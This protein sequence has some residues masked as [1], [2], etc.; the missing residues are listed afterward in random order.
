MRK[1]W[2][3]TREVSRLLKVSEASVRRWSDAGLMPVERVG[4]RG[5]R[6]FQEADVRRFREGGLQTV[7]AQREAARPPMVTFAGVSVALGSHLAT[8]YDSD[9]ARF[10]LTIPFLAEGLRQDQAC[11]VVAEARVL[12]GYLRELGAQQGV[13]LDAAMNRGILVSATTI[14]ATAEEA[15]ARWQELAWSALGQGSGVLRMVGEMTHALATLAPAGEL[16]PF[17][18]RVNSTIKRLPAV[19]V[20]QYDARHF[21]GQTILGAIRTHPDTF[22]MNQGRLLG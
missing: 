9:A 1:D 12:D 19:V 6:R 16:I 11:L 20:C 7:P 22:D 17:E 21:D 8:F 14:G 13:D 18:D 3:S 5:E 15:L 2:L 4:L 10:R